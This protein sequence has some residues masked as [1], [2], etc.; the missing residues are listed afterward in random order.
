MP[1]Q[2]SSNPA[3]EKTITLPISRFIEY[4]IGS[5]DKRFRVNVD[6]AKILQLK[7]ADEV[8][9]HVEFPSNEN[10]LDAPCV[11]KAREWRT[12]Y[13]TIQRNKEKAAAE[14]LAANIFREN[15]D[16]VAKRLNIVTG[17]DLD[18]C[19]TTAILMVRKGDRKTLE[20]LGIN[21]EEWDK[22]H[23]LGYI[24]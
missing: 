6:D 19:R 24:Q 16:K 22:T 13:D 1:Q 21:I 5:A 2:D 17:L 23:N 11:W 12:N 9:C 7:D 10:T 15:V 3:T 8:F 20:N 4:L 14:R 18:R